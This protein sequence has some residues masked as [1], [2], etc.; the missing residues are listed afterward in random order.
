MGAPNGI[1]IWIAYINYAEK[2]N[3]EKI[4]ERC[5]RAGLGWLAVKS[6][7]TSASVVWTRARARLV[8]LAHGAGLKIY[9]WNFSNPRGLEFQVGQIRSNIYTGVDGHIVNAEGA[10]NGMR[11]KANRFVDMIRKSCSTDWIAHAPFALPLSHPQFPYNE[12]G[13]LDAT[14]PQLYWTEFGDNGFAAE[15]ERYTSQ[16]SKQSKMS[17]DWAANNVWPIGVTYGRGTL[18]GMPRGELDIEDVSHFLDAF[19]HQPCSLYSYEAATS[20]V[21]DLLEHRKREHERR[22]SFPGGCGP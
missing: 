3:L 5:V 10:W 14:L 4:V 8:E 9:S 7:D 15:F 16:W 13:R 2:G 1:G 6:G 17:P 20:D 18:Y 19:E 21:W 11:D 12:F 22:M